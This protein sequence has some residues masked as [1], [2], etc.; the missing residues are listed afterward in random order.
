MFLPKFLYVPLH[1]HP[2]SFVSISNAGFL[3]K[4]ILQFVQC[5][6]RKF[7]EAGM[8]RYITAFISRF[9]NVHAFYKLFKNV[10]NAVSIRLPFDEQKSSE[11]E[12]RI[13]PAVTE[14]SITQQKLSFVGPVVC[15]CTVRDLI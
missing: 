10:R 9:C 7:K 13:F 14:V 8:I 15:V 12:T 3:K 1:S 11:S 2:S 4:V 5:F 6:C